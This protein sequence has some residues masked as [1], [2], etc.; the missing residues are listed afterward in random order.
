MRATSRR[1]VATRADTRGRRT[2]TIAAGKIEDHTTDQRR[3]SVEAGFVVWQSDLRDDDVGG[4]E[5]RDRQHAHDDRDDIGRRLSALDRRHCGHPLAQPASEI[6]ER[7]HEGRDGR[8]QRCSHRTGDAVA[9]R[10]KE[11]CGDYTHRRA[12]SEREREEDETLQPL[13]QA[14][15]DRR[16]HRGRS[17]EHCETTALKLLMSSSLWTGTARRSASA[18]APTPTF[19]ASPRLRRKT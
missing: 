2:I 16:H 14:P 10:E 5:H 4:A 1:P 12:R 19:I 3:S 8:C 15:D 13:G 9:G 6:P 7:H 11:D 17:Y 18:V